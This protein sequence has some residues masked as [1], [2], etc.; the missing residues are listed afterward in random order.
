MDIASYIAQ[1]GL[2][3]LIL[4]DVLAT[5]K[6]LVPRWALED[7][8]RAKDAVIAEKDK[9]ISEKSEDIRTLKDDLSELH[10]M[11]RDEVLPALVTSNQVAAGYIIQVSGEKS[12]PDRPQRRRSS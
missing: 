6:Y 1:F 5:R 12:T 7:T 3:G 11:T 8:I 10:A 9:M 2:V 4:I